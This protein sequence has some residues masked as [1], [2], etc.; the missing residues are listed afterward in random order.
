MARDGHRF[1]MTPNRVRL[2]EA[3]PPRYLDVPA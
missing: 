1:Y 2:V 3:V